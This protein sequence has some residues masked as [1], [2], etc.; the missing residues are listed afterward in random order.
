MS[1]CH[2]Q[3]S[4]SLYRQ[5]LVF[6]GKKAARPPHHQVSIPLSAGLGFHTPIV[7]ATTICPSGLNPFIGR[8]WF[9]LKQETR[10]Q[11]ARAKVSIPLSA[12]LGFH[13]WL[14]LRDHPYQESLNPFIGRAWFSR[15][16]RREYHLP[17]KGSQSLY[18]QGLVFTSP[19]LAC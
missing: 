7:T 19:W 2:E 12:G 13:L 4:Q 8:A 14:A 15:D 3:R 1:W 18:R 17:L 16:Q 9:S 5:G 11:R 10:E 6:T